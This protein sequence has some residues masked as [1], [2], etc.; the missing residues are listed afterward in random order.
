M[1]Y[2]PPRELRA[3][4]RLSLDSRLHACADS[5]DW[6][7]G[8]AAGVARD[9][10]GRRSRFQR[11]GRAGWPNYATIDR[12]F[13]HHSLRYENHG[14]GVGSYT[15]NS[16]YGLSRM[17]ER[18]RKSVPPAPRRCLRVAAL[19]LAPC[20]CSA[21]DTHGIELDRI[22]LRPCVALTQS[23]HSRERPQTGPT[24]MLDGAKNGG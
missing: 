9:R 1:G 10:T 6:S 24:A 16:S 21:R 7:A 12:N 5:T 4:R 17:D 13:L 2:L 8:P 18:S 3:S 15:M 22:E 11:L 23:T 14:M 20:A 19:P